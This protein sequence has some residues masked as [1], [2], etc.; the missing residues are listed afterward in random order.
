MLITGYF[1]CTQNFKWKK[2]LDLCLQ[3]I[4]YYGVIYFIFLALELDS[5]SIKRLYKILFHLPLY[6]GESFISCYVALYLL[7]PFINKLVNACTKKE[8]TVL[9]G[10]LLLLQTVFST[11]FL[12]GYFDA[13][14]WYSTVY[15]IGAY[16]R[17]YSN[18]FLKSKK[19]TGI[20]CIFCIVFSWL[21]I[22][23]ILFLTKIIGKHLPYYHF[24]NN[25]N[26]IFAILTAISV[27]LF[28]NNLNLG[29][30]KIV[31]TFAASTFGVLL[32]HQNAVIPKY[33]WQDIFNNLNAF[34]SYPSWKFILHL[35]ISVLL[36][37]ITCVFIDISLRKSI[38]IIKSLKIRN[39]NE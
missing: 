11:F 18:D 5:F 36:V 24:I 39:N 37:Y 2:I 13:I 26:K 10:I 31:N 22:I 20:V 29:T 3:T 25:A 4:F 35:I 1:T 8:L 14:G 30:N 7:S 33:I 34:E 32:L 15:I 27:F 19:I 12:N 21:S 28:F 6:F 16:L 17:L 23:G 9:I 38:L